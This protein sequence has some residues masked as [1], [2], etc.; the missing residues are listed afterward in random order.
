MFSP[1]Y[2]AAG[3]AD[4]EDYCAINVALY[5][6]TKRW[7][8]TERNS[9]SLERSQEV[10]R[11]GRSAMAWRDGALLIEI[12][13]RCAPA[14]IPIRGRVELRPLT[15]T[16]G[17][18]AL[19]GAGRH[20]W[21]PIAPLAEVTA[22]FDAPGLRWRGHGYFDH[23]IGDEALDAGFRSWTWSRG[24]SGSS[25]LIQFDVERRTGE[26][27][28]LGLQIEPSGAITHVDPGAP[29]KLETSFW[30]IA[31]TARSQ[32]AARVVETWED[33]PFYARSKIRTAFEGREFDAVHESLDLDRFSS[34]WVQ[35]LLGFRMPR[36]TGPLRG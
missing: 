25:A 26:H 8:M 10:L 3:S 6:A 27:D 21:R 35:S 15:L 34:R 22:D 33:T 17:A 1:Y 30:R 31:R 13:E 7:A 2:K 19:D 4:P 28:R 23:N 16:S 24:Q 36:R 20:L 5:G 32:G 11:V 29:E 18:F 14:P 9:A 12:D